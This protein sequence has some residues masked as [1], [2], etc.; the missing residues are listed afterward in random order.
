MYS[1]KFISHRLVRVD[2]LLTLARNDLHALGINN[3]HHVDILVGAIDV[4]NAV[5]AQDNSR[6]TTQRRR[7]AAQES[8][9][10]SNNLHSPTA[11]VVDRV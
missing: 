10:R 8:A 2:Q 6:S 1:S 7:P 9:Q 3:R 5:T 11:A 4:I